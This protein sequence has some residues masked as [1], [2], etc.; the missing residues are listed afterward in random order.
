MGILD[1]SLGTPAELYTTAPDTESLVTLDLSSS[2]TFADVNSYSATSSAD[3]ITPVSGVF[4]SVPDSAST[5]IL[6]SG[7]VLAMALASRRFGRAATA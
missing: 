7:A 6:L 5:A 1:S 2:N 3:G 4:A